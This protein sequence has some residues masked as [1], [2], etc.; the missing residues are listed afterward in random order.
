[1]SLRLLPLLLAAAGLCAEELLIRDLRVSAGLAPTDFS[2]TTSDELATT[3]GDDAFDDARCLGLRAAWSWSGAGRSWAPIVAAEMLAEDASYGDGGSY[4]Q[5]TLRGLA[6]IGWQPADAWTLSLL[7]LLGA[8]RPSF[9]VPVA[10]GGT[11]A[12]AGASASTGILVG[13]D[14]AFSRS[15][16]LGVEAGWIEEAA[17]LSGDGV[18][19]DLTRSG[20]SA[21]IGLAWVWSR[22]PI[23]LE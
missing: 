12:T 10:T 11:I 23:R 22:R 15:W 16:R 5:Y 3:S 20:V 7:A 1:M 2:Y 14:W 9:D 6:G 18:D 4:S 21:A 17:T 8:G 13:L 19:L